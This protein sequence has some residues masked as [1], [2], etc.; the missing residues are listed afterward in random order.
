MIT[1]VSGGLSGSGL[2]NPH[3]TEQAGTRAAY[4]AEQEQ[5]RAEQANNRKALETTLKG[6]AAFGP[7]VTVGK[8]A[9]A[10]QAR[11]DGAV[12]TSRLD[13]CVARGGCSRNDK[14]KTCTKPVALEGKYGHY[15]GARLDGD[16]NKVSDWC[17]CRGGKHVDDLNDP[18][19]GAEIA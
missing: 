9:G 1:K 13:R 7:P 17:G 5:K 19:N 16:R 12:P 15:N 11:T 14:A 6:K 10:A 8:R 4:L 3:A 18:N 2:S